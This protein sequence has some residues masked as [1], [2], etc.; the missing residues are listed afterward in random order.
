MGWSMAKLFWCLHSVGA[1]I[2]RVDELGR[3]T[4]SVLH[5]STKLVR[6]LKVLITDLYGQTDRQKNEL[7]VPKKV[8]DKRNLSHIADVC[9]DGV[10]SGLFV[11]NHCCCCHRRQSQSSADW[12]KQVDLREALIAT[13]V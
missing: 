9:G 4:V 13:F 6:S 3:Y 5:Q 11:G 12:S 10:M 2:A 8:G 1:Q 7:E